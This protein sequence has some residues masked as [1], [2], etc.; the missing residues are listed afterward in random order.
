ML[1]KIIFDCIINVKL[2]GVDPYQFRP[3]YENG[4]NVLTNILMNKYSKL[5][6]S[7]HHA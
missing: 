4:S 6:S 3:F 7:Q 5:K 2:A 1:H